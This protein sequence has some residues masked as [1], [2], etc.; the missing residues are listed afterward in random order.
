MWV[1]Y[2]F[3]YAVF[4]AMYLNFNEKRHYNGYI[5]GII[6]GFGISLIAL[7]FLFFITTK[8][9]WFYFSILFMQGILIGIYDSHIFVSSSKYGAG[10]TFGFMATSLFITLILWWAIEFDEFIKLTEFKIK[11][12]SLL[13]ILSA[14]SIS[15]WQ[16]MKV[17][18]KV[19]AEKFLYPAVISL[20]MMSIATRYIALWGG[21]EFDGIVYYLFVSC[22]VSGVYNLFIFHFKVK[23]KDV[24]K[25][26]LNDAIWLIFISII[27]ISAKTIAFREA[28]NPCYVMAL[29]LTSPFFVNILKQKKIRIT[30]YRVIFWISIVLLIL[31]SYADNYLRILF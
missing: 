5:L 3:I 1:I 23:G 11:F 28:Y 15:Y 9:T 22:F 8:L 31:Y 26:C 13:F 7:P 2:S 21:K 17:K 24:A 14:I 25:P 10:S 29:L 6:R 19:N 30:P 16:I 27:L 18:V 4:N 12:L 20:S